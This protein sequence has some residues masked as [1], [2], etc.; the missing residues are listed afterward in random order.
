M[1]QTGYNG[2][3]GL[4]TRLPFAGGFCEWFFTEKENA[5]ALPGIDPVTQYLD[6]EPTLSVGK[7]WYGSMKVPNDQ[8]GF[9]EEMQAGKGG[10][11]YKQTVNGLHVGDSATSRINMENLPY[12]EFLIVGRMRAG[13][14][15]LLLGNDENGFTFTQN[16]KSSSAKYTGTEFSFENNSLYKGLILTSF[17]GQAITPPPDYI[18]GTGGTYVVNGNLVEIIFFGSES[19]ITVEWTTARLAN[20]GAFPLLEVWSTAGDKPVIITIPIDVDAA[21]PHATLFTFYLPGSPGF[22]VI[23]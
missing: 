1:H 23:K 11:Y 8:L 20:F 16:F 12:H 14:L 22:I 13:G 18:S 19:E 5:T 3:Q 10:L 17:L 6:G 21:P 2:V 15:Y 4:S 9:S 7:S